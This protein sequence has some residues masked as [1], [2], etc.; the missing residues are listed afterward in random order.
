MKH[1]LLKIFLILAVVS[2]GLTSD[3]ELSLVV[4]EANYYLSSSNCEAAKDVLDSIDYNS[5]SADFVSLYASIYACR[6]GYTVLETL[7]DNLI[8]IDA[9]TA[10]LFRS[11]ANFTS[12]NEATADS[13]VYSNLKLAISEIQ[14]NSS[15][16][17]NRLL[18]YGDV[19]GTDLSMQLLFLVLTELGKY[20]KFY[21][22]GD[23]NGEKQRCLMNYNTI[24][25]ESVIDSVSADACNNRGEGPLELDPSDPD[26]I[27]R[28][29]EGIVL[30]SI[31][32]DIV[33]NL[34]FSDNDGLGDLADTASVFSSLLVAATLSEP[35]VA[36][37]DGFMTFTECEAYAVSDTDEL[38]RVFAAYVENFYL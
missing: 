25:V 15:L 33:S 19:K 8:N 1:F 2:C 12:S 20:M 28:A 29:C 16:T 10:G 7:F 3:K 37:Y 36:D 6:A 22:D 38:Q 35:A 23:V 34:T 18:K 13:D 27:R 24:S 14:R 5:E 32:G 17:S 11:L 26:F 30:H 4:D 21:G 31:F 9:T